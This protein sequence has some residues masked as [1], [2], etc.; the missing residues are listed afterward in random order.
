MTQMLY[1]SPGHHDWPQHGGT[2]EYIVVDEAG[3]DQAVLDGWHM[4]TGEALAA[5]GD[6]MPD[7]IT[8]EIEPPAEPKPKRKY[9][10]KP[11]A[12]D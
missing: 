9:T 1:K 5:V 6:L 12:S 8:H 3:I 10:R 2:F 4:T 7:L 11:K